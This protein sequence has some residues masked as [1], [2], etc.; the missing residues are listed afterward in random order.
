MI[1][2]HFPQ[3]PFPPQDEVRNM[4]AF[5]RDSM[6]DVLE[7]PEILLPEVSVMFIESKHRVQG[8]QGP[9]SHVMEIIY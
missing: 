1:I 2:L 9:R 6:T 4:P 5:F 8:V 3:V 7:A